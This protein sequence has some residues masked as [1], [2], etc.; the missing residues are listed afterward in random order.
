MLHEIHPAIQWSSDGRSVSLSY[1]RKTDIR[2]SFVIKRLFLWR[3]V[4]VR[5]RYSDS[6]T[7]VFEECADALELAVSCLRASSQSETGG[8]SDDQPNGP[9]DSGSKCPSREATL[10]FV[11]DSVPF[12][13]GA[14]TALVRPQISGKVW[15]DVWN[16]DSVL[17]IT[18]PVD[19]TNE[20]FPC[21]C[22]TPQPFGQ[23]AT[24][25][26]SAPFGWVLSL[27][28]VRC[29]HVAFLSCVQIATKAQS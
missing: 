25:L 24:A 23:Q 5:A 29:V 3:R 11:H 10:A 14:L 16:G 15:G 1:R 2:P 4:V 6:Q 22:S 20:C 27:Q 13:V 8:P 19:A 26:P 28:H 12:V 21:P 7:I 18:K 17:E 9:E